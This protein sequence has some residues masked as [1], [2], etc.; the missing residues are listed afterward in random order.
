LGWDP[1]FLALIDLGAIS[2]ER[3]DFEAPELDRPSAQK[4]WWNDWAGEFGSIP[5]WKMNQPVITLR[6]IEGK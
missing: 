2:Y 4:K 5:S 3:Q 1:P 6:A